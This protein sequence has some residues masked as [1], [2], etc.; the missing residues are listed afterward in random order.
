[1]AFNLDLKSTDEIK[2]EVERE[3]QP[4]PQEKEQ[5]NSVAQQNAQEIMTVDLDSL[6]DRRD[7][8]K[9]INNFGQDIIVQSG[10]KNAMLE[11]R[12]KYVGATNSETQTVANDLEELSIKMRDLDPSGINFT[13][14]GAFGKITQPVRRYFE[15]YKTADAEIS[16]I[17]QS[18]D[19]G[20]TALKHDCTTLEIEE[21]S[22]RKLTKELMKS[23]ELGKEL[24]EI[25]T[26]AIEEERS[27]N[28]DEDR[29]QY[30]ENEV[31]FPLR[32]RL[33]DF[34]QLLVVNQQGIVAMEVIRRNNNELI[35]SVER[36]KTVTVTSLR[37]AVTVAGALYNQ[38][39]VIE[40]VNLVNE[41]TN[42]MIASTSK[43]L[44]DQGVEIQRQ[45]TQANISPETLKQA[46]SDAITAM[47]DMMTYRQQALP[48]MR[49]TIDQFYE[50]AE[51]GERQ[52]NRI[53]F[54]E[55]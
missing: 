47:D 23:I 15:R 2:E 16:T 11:K 48:Q 10:N 8:A 37:T 38:K 20:K 55:E 46:F 17:I 34:Q 51:E 24:D 19:K 13:K 29:I 5:I 53:D 40:K 27:K 12:L 4:K 42:N 18:L 1:M 33:M 39:I 31:L 6:E 3:L 54:I 52:L 45:A 26:R 32:Q 44:K 22:M 50:L 14:R 28:G 43:M 35:R 7:I 9:V 36:A 25:L 30:V 41:T 21:V 49:A